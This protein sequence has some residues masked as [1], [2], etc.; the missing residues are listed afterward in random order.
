MQGNLDILSRWCQQA[1]QHIE[2]GAGSQLVELDEH[3]DLVPLKEEASTFW[4]FSK[5]RK[6]ALH[7]DDLKNMCTEL[8]QE[9]NQLAE[10]VGL[11]LRVASKLDSQNW[12]K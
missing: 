8:V 1:H 10:M 7:S 5:K 9:A 3:K 2:Q 11:E 6:V 12:E 4:P